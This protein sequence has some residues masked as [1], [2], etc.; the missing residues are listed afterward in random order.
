MAWSL[1]T[2]MFRITAMLQAL[3]VNGLTIKDDP[4]MMAQ[5]HCALGVRFDHDWQ[6]ANWW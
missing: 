1:A 2:H 5:V 4:K 6:N 3:T